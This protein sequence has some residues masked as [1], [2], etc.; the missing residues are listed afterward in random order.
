MFLQF[1]SSFL[2]HSIYPSWWT[3]VAG[4]WKSVASLSKESIVCQE[5]PVLS[6]HSRRSSIYEVP[7]KSTLKPMNVSMSSTLSP[8]CSN[9]SSEIYRIL[10][11]QTVILFISRTIIR[12]CFELFERLHS[13]SQVDSGVEWTFYQINLLSLVTLKRQHLTLC[14]VA[15]NTDLYKDFIKMNRIKEQEKRLSSLRELVHM[16]PAPHYETLK[17]LIE[18]L[19]RVSDNQEFNM[20]RF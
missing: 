14:I 11:S 17:F 19:R 5:T 3:F 12:R 2:L 1:K 8:H 6:M 4:L 18:H 9:L 7:R 13:T 15:V 20:V 10:Y 16:L